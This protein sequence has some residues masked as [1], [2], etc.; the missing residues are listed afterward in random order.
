M[1]KAR[2]MFDTALDLAK[3]IAKPQDLEYTSE[4]FEWLG[5]FAIDV[6]IN[7]LSSVQDI[8]CLAINGVVVLSS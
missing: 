5:T 6:N 3:F 4:A 7:G 2:I 1:A 8:K